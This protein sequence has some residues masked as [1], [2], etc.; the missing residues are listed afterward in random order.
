LI[1]DVTDNVN[2]LY[3]YGDW[4][5]PD[6]YEPAPLK[7][8]I[9]YSLHGVSPSEYDD[10]KPGKYYMCIDCTDYDFT[11][12]MT[13]VSKKIYRPIFVHEFSDTLAFTVNGFEKTGDYTYKFTNG[14]IVHKDMD[15]IPQMFNIDYT[16]KDNSRKTLS[17]YNKIGVPSQSINIKRYQDGNNEKL[18]INF[19]SPYAYE[20]ES[21]RDG[22]IITVANSSSVTVLDS[23]TEP[24]TSIRA[25]VVRQPAFNTS[26]LIDDMKSKYLRVYGTTKSGYT[27]LMK[28]SA[29]T[30]T[31]VNPSTTYS[32]GMSLTLIVTTTG[33]QNNGTAEVTTRVKMA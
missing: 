13:P 6:I 11:D 14:S 16:I 28:P 27:F 19:I 7:D 18:N 4:D 1:N 8:D 23:T 25:E 22:F 29:Y 10:L 20:N 15:Y 5:S 3:N 24:I 2:P 9:T 12:N 21:Y 31:V 32:K 30:V 17:T 26:W 33:T